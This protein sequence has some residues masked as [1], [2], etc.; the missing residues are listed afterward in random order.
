MEKYAYFFLPI[1][2]LVIIVVSGCVSQSDVSAGNVK[3]FSMDISPTFE[4]G[5][6]H[7]QFSLKEITV[8]KGD[9]VR[10]HISAAGGPQ[11]FNRTGFNRTDFNTTRLNS[12]R[13]NATKGQPGFRNNSGA[14]TGGRPGGKGMVKNRSAG[15]RIMRT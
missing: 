12:T 5:T 9:T 1:F 11:G 4:N 6:P 15:K 3:E 10:I 7:A 14:R 13:F 2:L 8:N